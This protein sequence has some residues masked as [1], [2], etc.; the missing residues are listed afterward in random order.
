[1]TRPML[2]KTLVENTSAAKALVSEHG[3]SLFIKTSSHSLLLDVGASGLFLRNAKELGVPIAD[4]DF[5][6]VSHGHFDH[7]GGLAPFLQA[8]ARA[9][10]FLHRLAFEQYYAA[11]PD[12]TL[13]YIG[14]D[15]SLRHNRRLVFTSDRFFISHGIQVFS[16]V[17]RT[18]PGPSANAGLL[19]AHAGQTVADSFAHEQNLVVE[20]SG[21]TLLVTGC[22]HNGIVNILER[23][24][25]LKGRMP[26][27][28]IGGFHLSSHSGTTE[29]AAAIDSIARYLLATGAT[30]YTCHCTGAAPYQRL[31]AAMGSRI[32]YLSAGSKIVI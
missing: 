12:N 25:A 28:V 17:P 26:D 21:K 8:N 30:F 4:V 31:K 9:E 32:G 29:P 24:R 22:A 23:F 10:V 15:E 1:M 27:C 18:T 7:G 6:V 19:M 5:L 16:N 14:L 2:V 11:R 3:L 20:D 13:Q